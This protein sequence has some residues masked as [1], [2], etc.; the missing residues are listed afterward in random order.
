MRTGLQLGHADGFAIAGSESTSSVATS[1]ASA[2]PGCA[3]LAFQQTGTKTVLATALAASPVRLLNPR[4]HG[5]AAWIFLSSLGGGLVDGDGVALNI[6]AA[7]GTQAFISTQASTKVYRSPAGCS[8]RLLAR[9]GDEAALAIVPDPVVCFA[10]AKYTQNTD[11]ALEPRA[12]LFLFDGYTS[13]RAARGERWLFARYASRTAVTRR[14][15]L[16]VVDATRLDHECGPIASRMGRFDVILSLLAVGPR[17][18]RVCETIL[19]QDRNGADGGDTI[20]AASPIGTDGAILRVAAKR[21]E[22]ALRMFRPS[23]TDLARDLGDNPFA[24]KW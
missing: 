18:S 7:R 2:G 10:G 21:T 11:I 3:T 13:G 23:F 8:Q 1:V 16:L 17:F 9:V 19:A 15:Q 5:S 20:A 22:S 12:S 6:D 24:R 14:G 4:N